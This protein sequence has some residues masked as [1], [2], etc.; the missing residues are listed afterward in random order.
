MEL[1]VCIKDLKV[2]EMQGPAQMNIES[3]CFDSRKAAPSCLFVAQKGTQSDG[4]RYIEDVI[5]KGAKAIVL[6]PRNCMTMCAISVC[7]TAMQL[8]V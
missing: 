7:T 2:L 8:W 1:S 3:I 5:A 4:H 6:C